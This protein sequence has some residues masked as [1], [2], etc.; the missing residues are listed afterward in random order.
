MSILTIDVDKY[1]GRLEELIPKFEPFGKRLACSNALG[2]APYRVSDL[3][4]GKRVD[5]TLLGCVEDWIKGEERR[6]ARKGRAA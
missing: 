2:V 5:E 3:L 6:Q 4:N 1:K